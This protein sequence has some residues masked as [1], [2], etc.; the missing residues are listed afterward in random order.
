MHH[1][2]CNRPTQTFLKRGHTHGHQLYG[3]MLN[4]TTCQGEEHQMCNEI[5]WTGGMDYHEKTQDNEGRMVCAEKGTLGHY[6][7]EYQLGRLLWE[8]V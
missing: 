7:R 3:R 6:W 2:L 4:I 1:K 5:T 8:P